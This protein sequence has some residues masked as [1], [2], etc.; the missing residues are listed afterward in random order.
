MTNSSP[1]RLL[2]VSAG[3]LSFSSALPAGVLAQRYGGRGSEPQPRLA[4][5]GTERQALE[6]SGRR[7]PVDAWRPGIWDGLYAGL[8]AGLA[9]GHA[10]PAYRYDSVDLYGGLLGG[11]IG[12]NWQH[13]AIVLG[14]E[15]D[16]AWSDADGGR[17]QGNGDWL[18]MRNSWL[19]SLR[20]RAGVTVG[21]ALLYATGGVALGGFEGELASVGGLSSNSET[22]LGYVL[23]GGIE[24]K[25][26]Q[27]LSGRL[28]ALH[29]GFND[30]T[31]EFATGDLR[32]DLSATTIRAGLTYH[33]SY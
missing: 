21:S 33:F 27:S 6:R 13:G 32:A 23:G 31:F 25:L 10:G 30:K 7:R 19:S 28:E 14:L 24:M 20:L 15:T 22:R 11:H 17:W 8:D 18:G 9:W 5:L 2:A 16:A 3:L 29:Y 4:W 26:T 12:Y 1:V